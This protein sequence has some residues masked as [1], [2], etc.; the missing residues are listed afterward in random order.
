MPTVDDLSSLR[1]PDFAE[2]LKRLEELMT[3]SR[4]SF[5]L[6]AGCSKCAGLPLTTELTDKTLSNPLLD[7][8]AKGILAALRTHFDGASNANIED[9]LSELIDLLASLP[10]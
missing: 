10:S 4:R 8:A 3:Q 7:D 9:Y 2:A 6:G 5:L 1:E